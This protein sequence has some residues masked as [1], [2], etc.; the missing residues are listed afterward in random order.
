MLDKMDVADKKLLDIADRVERI[1][2]RQTGPIATI[3]V[4]SR[5]HEDLAMDG[6]HLMS[7]ACEIEE[8][9][10]VVLSD[11]AIDGV[12]TVQSLI[13]AVAVEIEESEREKDISL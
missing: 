11:G 2:R 6:I 13:E 4:T 1:V 3:S 9:F 10:D 8:E 12:V 7:I 5:L